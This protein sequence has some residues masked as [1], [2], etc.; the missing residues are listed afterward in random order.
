MKK[1]VKIQQNDKPVILGSSICDS[2]NFVQFMKF[3]HSEILSIKA[4]V[5]HHM[6]SSAKEQ[7]SEQEPDYMKALIRSL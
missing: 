5:I 1:I 7:E 3:I 2:D 4:H 6:Q